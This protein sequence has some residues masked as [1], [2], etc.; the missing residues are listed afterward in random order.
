[1]LHRKEKRK[2]KRKKTRMLN[3]ERKACCSQGFAQKFSLKMGKG[4]MIQL[5]VFKLNF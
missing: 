5:A 1:V 2:E 4:K 3:R